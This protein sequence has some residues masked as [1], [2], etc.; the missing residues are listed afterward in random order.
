MNPSIIGI[1]AGTFTTL[2]VIPQVVQTLRTRN[3]RDLSI[4]QPLLLTIGVALWAIYGII[5]RDL[6]LIIAN[7]I[8]LACNA[9]LTAMK[10]RYG[11]KDNC[12]V[13]SK[14]KET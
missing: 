13:S 7:V 4:W 5:I 10:L 12:S 9:L 6:P 14:S 11:S 2:A 8:A 3:V 1:I